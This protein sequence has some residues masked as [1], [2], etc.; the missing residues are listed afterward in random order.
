LCSTGF[1]RTPAQAE[2]LDSFAPIHAVINVDVPFDT[3]VQR[4]SE[5]LVHPPSGRIYNLSFN[6]PKEQ[7]RIQRGKG[8]RHA[9]V[10]SVKWRI[11]R[12]GEGGCA[13]I[14]DAALSHT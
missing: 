2:F 13:Q 5:R 4:L 8:M 12:L 9:G 10:G 1:P 7:V 11:I 3:I 6:P 14:P